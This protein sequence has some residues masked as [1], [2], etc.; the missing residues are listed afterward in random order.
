MWG[1]IVCAAVAV[2]VA[3]RAP[4]RRPAEPKDDYVATREAAA[5]ETLR[6][7]SLRIE[8]LELGALAVR[9]DTIRFLI[10]NESN[11]AR[12]VGVSV[13]TEPGLWIRGAWQRGYA[14]ALGANERR[15][16]AL[17]Y[18]I[19]RLTPEG[20]LVLLVGRPNGDSARVSVDRPV[21]E[22]R[23]AIGRGNP[24]A[25][26]PRMNFEVLRTEHFDVYA[27]KG[28]PGA[29]DLR[30]VADQREEAVEKS[31]S[32]PRHPVS[33]EGRHRA[34]SRFGDQVQRDRSRGNGMGDE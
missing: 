31:R 1:R 29:R 6:G 7:D 27:Y 5:N 18:S 15:T 19:R 25:I 17:A 32:A 22:R 13:R 2:A 26:D 24:A 10:T 16:V 20:R 33:P 12:V 4:S 3:C 28:S 11:A 23:F 21:I 34:L 14:V 30:R 8:R 9:D